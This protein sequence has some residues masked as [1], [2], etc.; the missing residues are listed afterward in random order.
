M[1]REDLTGRVFGRLMVIGFDHMNSHRAS[2]WACRCS[3]GI[4]KAVLRASLINGLTRSCGCFHKEQIS[5]SN[6]MAETSFYHRWEGLIARCTNKKDRSWSGYG[7]RGIKVCNEWL[8][9]NNFRH[10]MH[11]EYLEHI[12]RHGAKNTS[13]DRIDN[14]GPYSKEN[15]RWATRKEQANNRRSNRLIEL[16]GQRNTV[17]RWSEILGINRSVIE[18]RLRSGWSVERALTTEVIK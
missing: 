1:A 9:F 2:M 17:G 12:E 6:G 16:E 3:C 18:G 10:D 5:T 7:G 13:L 8:E 4:E 14:E 15:C 11:Q